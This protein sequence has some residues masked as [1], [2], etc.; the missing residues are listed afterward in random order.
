MIVGLL[1]GWQIY[2]FVRL[3]F[4]T[5]CFIPTD[6]MLPTIVAGDYIAVSLLIPGKRI[7][8]ENLNGTFELKRNK[9]IRKVSKYDIVVFNYPY[10]GQEKKMVINTEQYHCKRCVALPGEMYY[11][12]AENNMTDSIFL[13]KVGSRLLIDS[14]NFEDYYRCIEY[15]TGIMPIKKNDGVYHADTLLLNYEFK[16]DYYFMQGDN[17]VNSYD[18]RTW[19]ILPED[20]IMGVAAFVWYSKNLETQE[21]RW[22]RLF[23]CL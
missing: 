17:I 15:E 14:L 20:F 1:G 18:S 2:V 21:I 16:N 12:K 4:Y 11:W 23:H 6:S 3:Y 9:G 7:I 10:W 19:G 5:S 22:N 8:T 13:P